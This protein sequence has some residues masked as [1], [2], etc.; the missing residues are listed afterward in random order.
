MACGL[1]VVASR[2]SALPELVVEGEG[3]YLCEPGDAAAFAE[4][5][6]GLRGNPALRKRMGMF[7]RERVERLFTLPKMLAAYRD[8]FD[9]VH[10]GP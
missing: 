3:G 8:L 10:G 7:N 4:K 9:R 1:P 6:E 2:G 5:L